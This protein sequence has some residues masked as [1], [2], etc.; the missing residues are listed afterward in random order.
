MILEACDLVKQY[1]SNLIINAINYTFKPGT[2]YTIQ[3][4]NGTGKTVLLRLLVGL[5]KPTEGFV[6]YDGLRVGRDIDFPLSLGLLIEGP[7]FI[8][9]W[10]GLKNLEML[11]SLKKICTTQQICTLMERFSL[12]PLSLIPYKAYS[13]GMKQKLGIIAAFME[14]PE[15]IVLD[16]PTNALDIESLE[17]LKSMLIEAVQRGATV[18]ISSHDSDF[19]LG[20]NAERLTL[21]NGQLLEVSES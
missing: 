13:L 10:T 14:E 21:K 8:P 7:S 3:A 9:Y 11:A 12:D 18:L 2:I 15:L 5:I 1:K 20:L 16:E 6:A 17:V 4:P 19:L